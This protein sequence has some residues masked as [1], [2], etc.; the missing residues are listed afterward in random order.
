MATNK[1]SRV[2]DAIIT[3]EQIDQTTVAGNFNVD[4]FGVI[5]QGQV[6]L[7]DNLRVVNGLTGD[8]LP[9]KIVT[10]SHKPTGSL[11]FLPQGLHFFKYFGGD[12]SESIGTYTIDNAVPTLPTPLTL[13]G[14]I[15]ESEAIQL[16]GCYLNNCR[17]SLSDEDILN[18]NADIVG[19]SPSVVSA[20]ISYTPPTDDPLIFCGGVFTIGGVEWD[21][22]SINFVIDP[23]FIQ[24]YG[25]RTSVSGEKRLPSQIIRGG[26]NVISFDGV[27]NIT[28][29]ST[30]QLEDV[31]GGSTPP[32]EPTDVTLVLEFTQGGKSHTLTVVGKT[33][34]N[35]L[36]YVDSEENSKTMSFNG[37]GKS[38]TVSGDL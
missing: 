19:I 14:N 27:V 28:S 5:T 13:R 31:W 3:G 32:D 33:S 26:K 17:L 21:L 38:W 16:I 1:I 8:H 15:N 12:Y 29:D 34:Q 10:L 37:N 9:N 6:N 11:S 36:N 35:G 23:R 2:L 30:N 24:K 20:S 7:L 4:V 18:V 25:I 22:Q